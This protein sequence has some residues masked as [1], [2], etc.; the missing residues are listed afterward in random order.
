M[1]CEK[2]GGEIAMHCI[3][4]QARLWLS[5]LGGDISIHGHNLKPVRNK[6]KVAAKT[7]RD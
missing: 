6:V 4:N 2:I 7:W 3:G 5:K 1:E